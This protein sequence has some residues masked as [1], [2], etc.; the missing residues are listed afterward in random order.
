METQM[1]SE[2]EERASNGKCIVMKTQCQ[3]R[4][5]AWLDNAIDRKQTACRVWKSV[6]VMRKFIDAHVMFFYSCSISLGVFFSNFIFS[7]FDEVMISP[8]LIWRSREAS[9]EVGELWRD[10]QMS[11]GSVRDRQGQLY[12]TTVISSAHLPGRV[13]PPAVIALFLCLM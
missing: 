13:A 12:F 6:I 2:R 7:H 8:E 3:R 1:F 11:V 5:A 10:W 4:A 9:G